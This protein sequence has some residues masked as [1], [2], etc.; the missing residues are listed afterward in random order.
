MVRLKGHEREH[1]E[2]YVCAGDDNQHLHLAGASSTMLL[3]APPLLG[4]SLQP[5]ED[6]PG[7]DRGNKQYLLTACG[8]V[9]GV[10]DRLPEWIEYHLLVGVEHFYIYDNSV[11]MNVST[12]TATHRLLQPY[13]KKGIV[14]YVPW[15]ARILCVE[16]WSM[17]LAQ[18]YCTFHS[19]GSD[20]NRH[21]SNIRACGA[22]EARQSGWLIW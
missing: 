10:D 8:L 21:V 12:T 9:E 6:A 13:M 19:F 15:P 22:L 20:V 17:Q 11:R 14:T 16:Q 2:L 3:R 4:S 7:K 18:V 5:G 1:Q